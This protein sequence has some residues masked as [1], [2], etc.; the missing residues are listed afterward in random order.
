[1]HFSYSTPWH[2]ERCNLQ[3][4]KHKISSNVI[5]Y[6]YP[7]TNDLPNTAWSIW[8]HQC[9]HLREC[10]SLTCNRSNLLGTLQSVLHCAH[11]NRQYKWSFIIE[12]HSKTFL[13]Y[14]RYNFLRSRQML[15]CDSLTWDHVTGIG[16]LY[17]IQHSTR[18]QMSKSVSEWLNSDLN[19]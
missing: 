16:T 13:K 3:Y 6:A 10:N 18:P 14:F 12:N 8:S 5:T 19:I 17:T 11:K 15:K 1:M 9:W 2:S 7:T 4:S